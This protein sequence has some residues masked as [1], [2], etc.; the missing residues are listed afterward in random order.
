[1]M[2]FFIQNENRKTLITSSNRRRNQLRRK[3]EKKI[4]DNESHRKEKKT[5]RLKF[6]EYFFFPHSYKYMLVLLDLRNAMRAFNRT[7][8]KLG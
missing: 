3:E 1:M 2:E 6:N 5:S 8:V 4:I 7:K